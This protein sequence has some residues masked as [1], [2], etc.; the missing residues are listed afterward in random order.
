M[1]FPRSANSSISSKRR[2][3]SF[4]STPRIRPLRSTFSRPVNSALNPAPSCKS[5]SLPFT[6]TLPSV[7]LRTPEIIFSSVLF[8]APF[9]PRMPSVVPGSTVRS[10]SFSAMNSSP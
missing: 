6:S 1:N 4:R 7:G 9:R 3:I 10:M 8:P 2:S 5:T